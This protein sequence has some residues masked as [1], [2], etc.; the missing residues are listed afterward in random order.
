MNLLHHIQFTADI[1]TTTTITFHTNGL[2]PS[3]RGV[4]GWAT[5]WR[6]A[7]HST[8]PSHSGGAESVQHVAVRPL[9]HPPPTEAPEE[10]GG[11]RDQRCNVGYPA[12]CK[13]L[14]RIPSASFSLRVGFCGIGWTLARAR[15]RV[16]YGVMYTAGTGGRIAV[17]GLTGGSPRGILYLGDAPA[18]LQS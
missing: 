9:A 12:S 11:G 2:P 1:H 8:S 6:R 7:T 13:K 14:P 5:G 17:I 18:S 3:A 15:S 4:G 16:V 10:S